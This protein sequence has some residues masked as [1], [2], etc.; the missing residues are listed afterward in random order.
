MGHTAVPNEF[1]AMA[2]LPPDW[3]TPL[4]FLFP[5]EALNIDLLREELLGFFGPDVYRNAYN[6]YENGDWK[7][8][9]HLVTVMLMKPAQP[10]KDLR[11]IIDGILADHD[12][13]GKS[14]EQIKAEEL[15]AAK[16]ELEAQFDTYSPEMQK[17]LRVTGVVKR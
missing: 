9:Q 10:E 7:N 15:E 1:M 2:A 8:G 14:E 5:A 6:G 11:I 16:Q 13:S 3:D 17:L 12:K 4:K